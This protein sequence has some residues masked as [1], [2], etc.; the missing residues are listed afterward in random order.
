MVQKKGVPEKGMMG[1]KDPMRK[2]VKGK[3]TELIED[4]EKLESS[5]EDSVSP[6]GLTVK[7]Q[8]ERKLWNI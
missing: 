4:V 2:V 7:K 1:K 5:L 3:I 6:E 8:R